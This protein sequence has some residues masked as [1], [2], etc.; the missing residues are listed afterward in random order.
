ML[1]CHHLTGADSFIVR[2]AVANV[3]HL[4]SVIENFGRYGTPTTALILSSP[5][6]ERA[7]T[8]PPA[9][10]PATRSRRARRRP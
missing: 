3:K 5:V 7:I 4:E 10:T 8:R 6:E 1:E 9:V 2:V